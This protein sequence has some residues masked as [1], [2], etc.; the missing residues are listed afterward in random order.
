MRVKLVV[1][2]MAGTTVHDGD[3]VG[4]CFRAA[5]AAAGL[6]AGPEAINAVMGLPK[7]EAIRRLTGPSVPQQRVDAI[8]EDFVARMMTY[9]ETHSAVREVDGASA[10]FARLRAAGVKVGLNTGFSRPIVEVL[11]NRLAWREGQTFDASVT[12]DEV[13]RGRPHPDMIL[14]LMRK[15]D[16]ADARTV[17][18]VGDTPVDLEEGKAAGCGWNIGITS[19]THTRAQLVR[20]P[21]THLIDGLAELVAVLEVG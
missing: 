4:S 14:Y 8:H 20:S 17:A 10:L 21:H 13:P 12:S 19:G 5:L 2:D 9:Y 11:L 1:F 15:L 18:K 7:P 16:I 6:S 3:A